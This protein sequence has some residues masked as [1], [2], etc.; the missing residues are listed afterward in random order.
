[1]ERPAVL[2]I[3]KEESPLWESLARILDQECQATVW[4]GPMGAGTDPTPGGGVVVWDVQG[5]TSQERLALSAFLAPDEVGVV[6]VSPLESGLS[7]LLRACGA[8]SLVAAP[9]T[10]GQLAAAVE[11]ALAAQVRLNRLLAERDDLQRQL[12]ERDV[13]ERAKRVL[14]AAAGHS[15]S[16]AMGQLQKQARNTNQ[17]LIEVAGKVLTAYKIF[18][19]D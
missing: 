4:R 1:M 10:P 7:G 18:N 12:R 13:I 6:V 17:R 16:E 14:M 11:M 8:W 5:Y 3:Q 2:L 15:E 9:F 19:G